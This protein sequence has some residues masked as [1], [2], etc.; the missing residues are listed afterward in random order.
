MPSTLIRQ[1]LL[2]KAR[3]VVVKVGSQLLADLAAGGLSQPF[4]Q[5]LADQIAELVRRGYS[6]TLVSSGAI[7]A[8]RG[9]LG[10][11]KKPTDIGALQAVA[12][13]GQSKLMQAWQ[14]VFVGHSIRVGQ[15]LLNRDDF[16]DRKRYLN[17]RN[18]IGELH[19]CG[20]LPIVNENDTVSVDEIRLG[21]NDVLAAMLAGAI[22]AEVL[23]LLTS[24]SGLH[25]A[26]GHVVDLI[27]DADAAQALV[28]DHKSSLGSGGMGTKLQAGRM[29][30]DAG[31]IA[32]IAGGREPSVL[33]RLLSGEKL[34]TV[35]APAVKRLPSR[36]RWI[37]HTVRPTGQLS[38]DDGAAA[39][40]AQRGKSLLASGI[41]HIAGEFG[42][43]DVVAVLDTAGREIARGLSNYS[44]AEARLIMG[45]KSG[46]FG[47]LLGRQAYDEVIHRDNMAITAQPTNGT[48]H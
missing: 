13:I 32:L 43:G 20:A 45:R 23:V 12:A 5:Q 22:S 14:D 42:E 16:E 26:A 8:G 27:N 2:P 33:L 24:V 3:R 41:T 38:V 36:R 10:L 30:S 6:I 28:G 29:V 34:G 18:C 19:R 25:D 44:A 40:V 4:M 31:E 37:A 47:K 35:F 48:E 46:E 11:K 7:A 1:S 9:M 21:D 39:A 15:M 17:L